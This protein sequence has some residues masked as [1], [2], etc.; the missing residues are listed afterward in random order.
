M[1]IHTCS[2]YCDRPECVKAQRDELRQKLEKKEKKR[3]LTF[4]EVQKILADAGC[5]PYYKWVSLTHEEMREAM[6]ES[7]VG[8]PYKVNIPARCKVMEVMP[9]WSHIS[10]FAELIEFKLRE[11]NC[12]SAD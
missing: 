6:R 3:L 2:Y 7:Q 9:V 4:E 5:N 12:S 1:S 8:K 10:H 11:K